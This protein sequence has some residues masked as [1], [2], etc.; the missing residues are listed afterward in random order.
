MAE[1]ENLLLSQILFTFM[2]NIMTLIYFQEFPHKLLIDR[3]DFYFSTF[4]SSLIC[5]TYHNFSGKLSNY[6]KNI[7]KTNEEL[8]ICLN[9][10]PL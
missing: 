4:E 10:I 6:L 8:M 7:N 2:Y 9:L 3:K 5:V 1:R